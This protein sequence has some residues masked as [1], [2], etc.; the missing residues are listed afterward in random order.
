MP[1]ARGDSGIGSSHDNAEQEHTEAQGDVPPL[2]EDD[3]EDHRRS[4]K[5]RKQQ[6]P[7]VETDPQKRTQ[8]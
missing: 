5:R 4:R 8:V 6:E 1:G 3:D 7:L 2:I